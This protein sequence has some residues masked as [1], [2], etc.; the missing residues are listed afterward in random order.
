MCGEWISKGTGLEGEMVPQGTGSC[1]GGWAQPTGGSGW[2]A[3]GGCV[4]GHL[5]S[6]TGKPCCINTSFILSV[7]SR[8]RLS[9]A[10]RGYQP[11]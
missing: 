1:P 8:E 10:A 5:R 11:F 9:E 6:L 4:E 3:G 7:G 2:G